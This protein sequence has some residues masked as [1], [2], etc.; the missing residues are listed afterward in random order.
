M[1]FLF[2]KKSKQQSNALPPASRQITSSHGPDSQ[3]AQPNGP[4]RKDSDGRPGPQPQTSNSTPSGSVNNSLSS[5]Q[6]REGQGAIAPEP[7][8][9]RERAGSNEQVR[10]GYLKTGPVPDTNS[11]Q[12]GALQ[13]AR[14]TG[15]PQE[16]P[17]PWSSRRLNFT[18]GN[19]FPRYGAAINSVASKDGTIYLMG[20]LVGG[21]TVKGDLWLTE[22]GNGSM[23]CY[24]ISTTGDGPGPRVGH[25]SLLV[26][27]AFIV[28]GGDT[29]L[30]D[31][32]DLDDTLYLLNTCKHVLCLKASYN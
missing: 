13:N 5:L 3:P 17:Y 30:T 27:N 1:S 22:M 24:P 2:G 26:G 20:G 25:A 7:K 10:E 6:G 16:S 19:P 21:A 23:A 9:L 18:A 12:Q 15:P 14:P 8:A 28:F 11:A 29:K 31:N 32:D 4:T